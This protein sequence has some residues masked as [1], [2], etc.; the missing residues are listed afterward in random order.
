MKSM[1]E[2]AFEVADE[3]AK[4]GR[5]GLATPPDD[6]GRPEDE[7]AFWDEVER[8]YADQVDAPSP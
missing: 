2:V 5:P 8:R 4:A 3:W 6:P 1:S 7:L